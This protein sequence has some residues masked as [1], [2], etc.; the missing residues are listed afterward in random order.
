M[1]CPKCNSSDLV[2][3]ETS[4]YPIYEDDGKDKVDFSAYPE[5]PEADRIMCTDCHTIYTDGWELV[6]NTESSDWD[7][8]FFTKLETANMGSTT[9]LE[10]ID[11]NI[12]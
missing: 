6:S 5:Y 2:Y 12:Y 10:I 7:E 3:L 4:A 8:I 11:E 1:K 9:Q